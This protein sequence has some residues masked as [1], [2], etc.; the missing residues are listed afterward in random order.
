[1]GAA[2]D[3]VVEHGGSAII[4]GTL[5]LPG[6]PYDGHTVEAV[7]KQLKRITGTQSEILIADRRYRGEKD[8]GK[9]PL[10]AP[11]RPSTADTEY[12]K[13]KQRK[14]FR[15]R[16][17]I[18]TTISHLKQ[19]YRLVRCF[20]KGEIGD[21]INISLSSV[22]YKLKMDPVQAGIIFNLF[23]TSLKNMFCR[24]IN[25]YPVSF[26]SKTVLLNI[27][28][29]ALFNYTSYFTTSLEKL[30]NFIR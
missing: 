27:N 17:G 3:L 21:Q 6:N 18:E 4:L 19:D 9:T 1:L 11:S 15:K 20:L 2:A 29:L 5:A 30:L 22:V 26:L 13:R 8:N 12:K 25:Y 7:L 24:K 16:A 23:Y 14:S 10:L 28:Y